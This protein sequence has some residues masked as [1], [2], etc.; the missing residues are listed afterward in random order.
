MGRI[1]FTIDADPIQYLATTDPSWT[2]GQ[3]VGATDKTGDTC[4]GGATARTLVGQ[5]VNLYYGYEYRCT[6][7]HPKECP[8]PNGV[9]KVVLWETDGVFSMGVHRVDDNSFVRGI[10]DGPLNRYEPIIWAPDSSRFY[11][12]INHTLHSASPE[13]AGYQPILPIAY[14]TYM[15][16]DGSMFLYLQPVGAGGAYDIWVANTDGSNAHNVTNAPDAFKVCARWGW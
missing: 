10:Y 1:F 13:A 4:T 11:F 2:Q 6:I 8:A 14:E 3:I 15:S 12:T 9:Y 16:A 5:T 7:S